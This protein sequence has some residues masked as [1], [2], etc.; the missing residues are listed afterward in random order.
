MFVL[1][2]EQLEDLAKRLAP[3]LIPMLTPPAPTTAPPELMED[4]LDPG[5]TMKDGKI[6]YLDPV[7]QTADETTKRAMKALPVGIA[8][9]V[10]RRG[11]TVI[12]HSEETMNTA[13]NWKKN[14][15]NWKTRTKVN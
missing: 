11:T 2:P 13:E 3:L 9:Y 6:I 1:K 7:V 5:V 8:T 4:E 12:N 10:G 15:S 14:R